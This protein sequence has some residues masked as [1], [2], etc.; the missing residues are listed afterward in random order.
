[1][2][3]IAVATSVRGIPEPR[4]RDDYGLHPQQMGR[5]QRLFATDVSH[6]SGRFHR[7]PGENVKVGPQLAGEKHQVRRQGGSGDGSWFWVG[8]DVCPLFLTRNTTDIYSRLGRQ[9]ALHFGSLGATVVVNDLKDPSSVAEEIR[10]A[11]GKAHTVVCSVS[12][13]EKIVAETIRQCG[14][15]DVV[16]N[17]AGFVRDKSIANMTDA[18][19]NSIMEVHLDGLY[20]ITKAAWPH[21]V[22]QSYG[23]VVNIASTSGIYGNF[24]QSNY[25]LAVRPLHQI[26]GQPVEP[27]H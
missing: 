7:D 5:R 25:S 1:M 11:G 20:K 8:L 21:F 22:R 9:Y 10:K 19:W 24:G 18:L 14:R 17:N 13:G 15:I 3:E 23:R 27:I 6:I 4:Y 26:A 16:V 2:P 12:E